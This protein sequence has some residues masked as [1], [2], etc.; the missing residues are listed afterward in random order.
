[1]PCFRTSVNLAMIWGPMQNNEQTAQGHVE[2][3]G[4]MRLW[5][6]INWELSHLLNHGDIRDGYVLNLFHSCGDDSA[7]YPQ[8]FVG[9]QTPF[10]S[11]WEAFLS[12][13][14]AFPIKASECIGGPKRLMIGVMLSF[15]SPKRLLVWTERI[16]CK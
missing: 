7:S 11:F 8:E 16:I 15:L 9:A 13:P 10:D 14:A 3:V 6:P 5:R 1:M 2:H 4:N 12:N